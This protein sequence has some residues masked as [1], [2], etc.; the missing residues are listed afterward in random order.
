MCHLGVFLQCL[1][2][3]TYIETTHQI[4]H[5][6]TVVGER[7][8]NVSRIQDFEHRPMMLKDFLRDGYCNSNGF[9][10][11]SRNKSTA[12]ISSN[13]P[14]IVLLRSRSKRA[15]A[16][17]ISAIQKV[18]KVVKFFH[19]ES[20]KVKPSDNSTKL[21]GGDAV[22]VK[23]KDILRW[24][25]FRDLEM[26]EK[27]GCTPLDL[28]RSPDPTVTTTS[29]SSSKR[30]S[31]RDSDFSEEELPDHHPWVEQNEEFLGKSSC[32]G[33]GQPANGEALGNLEVN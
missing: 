12:L 24:R 33:L 30:S 21:D 1:N 14:S 18:I 22:R 13:K 7:R 5:M 8:L 10:V 17:T 20:V 6:A 3:I 4:R 32:L 31:W 29:N 11:N 15:A 2:L 26:E 9:R 23:V 19:F 25:S 27:K 16:T 28:P